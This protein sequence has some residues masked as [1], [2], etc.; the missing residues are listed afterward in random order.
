M[1]KEQNFKRVK[2]NS[3]KGTFKGEVKN[4]LS[5]KSYEF[6]TEEV[7]RNNDD[8][9]LTVYAE[10]PDPEAEG[11]EASIALQFKNSEQPSGDFPYNAPEIRTL[12][13]GRSN[14][15]TRYT[16]KSG[17]V[18]FQHHPDKKIN[19]KLE[20]ETETLANDQYHVTVIF[21]ADAP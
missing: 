3:V 10:I 11:G 1:S 12:R 9:F 13:Y 18:K 19:G 21:V 2:T 6:N 16:A 14:P 20:F 17:T 7:W 4:L 8:G 5:N 15:S